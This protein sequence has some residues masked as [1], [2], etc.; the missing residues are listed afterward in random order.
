M[1]KSA[2][3]KIWE[4]C[5]EDLCVFPHPITRQVSENKNKFRNNYEIINTYFIFTKRII[6]MK[7]YKTIAT[8]LF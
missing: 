6:C 1:G 5:L 4:A 2:N 3:C 7:A 8:T